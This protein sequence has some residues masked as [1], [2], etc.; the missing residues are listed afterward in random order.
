MS[1][2]FGHQTLHEPLRSAIKDHVTSSAVWDQDMKFDLT[3]PNI[4]QVSLEYKLAV[5][6]RGGH[7]FFPLG[8]EDFGSA[9]RLCIWSALGAHLGV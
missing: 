2:H 1:I 3:I 4:P 8:S 5:F 6:I 9:N 7:L